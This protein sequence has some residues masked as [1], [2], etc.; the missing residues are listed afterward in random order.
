[1]RILPGLSY[2]A[3]RA[4]AAQLR[5]GVG[6]P[7][8]ATELVSVHG[9][10]ATA[11]LLEAVASERQTAEWES[12]KRLQLVWSGPEREGAGSRDTAVIVRDLFGGAERSVIVT[13][14]VVYGGEAILGRLAERMRE[15][16]GLDVRLFLNVARPAAD[17]ADEAVLAR[18]FC[19]RF[20]EREWPWSE[21]PRLYYD[22]R[23]LTLNPAE[24][25][26][27]HAK[28]VVVDDERAFVT[29]ANL[30]EAAQYRNIE[31]G[32]LVN[33]HIFARALSSQFLGLLETGDLRQMSG[34]V[35]L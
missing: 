4:L 29:S 23:S 19:E 26:V 31:C 35:A 22:P 16:P 27:L 18:R 21:R 32:V 15:V 34:S 33:D 12:D 9:A 1:M 2:A 28:C 20:F 13:G 25:A 3:L 6:V 11:D 24:R 5:A 17:V 30:T 14:Y 8:E 7:V 10:S